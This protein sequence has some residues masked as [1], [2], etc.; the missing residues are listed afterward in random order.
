MYKYT[1]HVYILRWIL[2]FTLS[3]EFRRLFGETQASSHSSIGGILNESTLMNAFT[4]FNKYT[5]LEE[6]H[7]EIE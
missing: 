3:E 5:A 1:H 4:E 6:Y 2:D 7:G